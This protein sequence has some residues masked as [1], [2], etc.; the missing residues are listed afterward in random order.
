[1]KENLVLAGWKRKTEKNVLVSLTVSLLP[2]TRVWCVHVQ[3]L[4]PCPTLCNPVD[5]SLSGSSVY[6]IFQARIPE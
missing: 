6:G 2:V 3:C 5:Y 1:M 4:Q